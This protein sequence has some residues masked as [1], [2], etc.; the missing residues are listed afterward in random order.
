MLDRRN[1]GVEEGVNSGDE[2]EEE[3]DVDWRR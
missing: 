3:E 2:E 1:W